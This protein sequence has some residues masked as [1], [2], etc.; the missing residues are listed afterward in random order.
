MHLLEILERRQD[1]ARILVE[2]HL[3]LAGGNLERLIPT[4]G[5]P[6]RIDARALF[7]I[8]STQGLLEPL[9]I[10]VTHDAGIALRT[11][12]S[13]IGRIRWIALD[14]INDAI[15]GDVHTC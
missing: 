5:H 3:D 12:L 8:G 1:K 13:D 14:L 7:W 11:K 4:N 10:I 6:F 2:R 9:W 15:I